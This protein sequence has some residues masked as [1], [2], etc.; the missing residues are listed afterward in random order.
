MKKVNR[1][2]N[3]ISSLKVAISLLIVIAIA[4]ALGTAIPQN[5]SINSYLDHYDNEPWMGIIKGKT[6]LFLQLD[7]IYQSS[8]FLFLLTWL[9]IALI[10]CK[11]T[12]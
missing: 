12:V 9:S 2:I 1:F 10:F 5:E 4:C 11:F 7:H 3:G 6:L 8:W